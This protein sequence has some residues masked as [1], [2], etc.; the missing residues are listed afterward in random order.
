MDDKHYK[1]K[2]T[3]CQ[4]DD[5]GGVE[6]CDCQGI[7]SCQQDFYFEDDCC[8]D[9]E[10]DE[11][12]CCEEDFE[13]DWLDC[14]CDEELCDCDDLESDVDESEVDDNDNIIAAD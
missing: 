10:C 9:E 4:Q 5:L 2:D 1:E 13:D 6:S 12:D 8:D 7:C 3:C 11:C 14:D